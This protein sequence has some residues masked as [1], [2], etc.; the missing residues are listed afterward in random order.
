MGEPYGR[1]LAG[2]RALGAARW[3]ISVSH[4]Q[5]VAVAF[6]VLEDLPPASGGA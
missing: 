1:K 5:A 2:L 3:H 6:V 4:I